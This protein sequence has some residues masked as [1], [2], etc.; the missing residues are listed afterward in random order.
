MPLESRQPRVVST[1]YNLRPRA[2]RITQNSLEVERFNTYA[3]QVCSPLSPPL[4]TIP[5][6]SIITP[7]KNKHF[8][9]FTS[10]LS[11]TYTS[12]QP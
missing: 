12:S 4:P 2:H 5:I 10:I 7:F 11:H 6:P 3:V 9:Q 1:H 8:T